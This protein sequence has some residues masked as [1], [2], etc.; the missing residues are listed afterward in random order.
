M[1]SNGGGRLGSAGRRAEVDLNS[2]MLE[3]I[4]KRIKR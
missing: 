4:K 1:Q 3:R 2:D